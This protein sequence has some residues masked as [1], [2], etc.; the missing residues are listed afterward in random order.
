MGIPANFSIAVKHQLIRVDLQGDWNSQIDMEYLTELMEA[1]HQTK[2]APWGILVDM[3][4]WR[5]TD[6]L[7]AFKHNNVLHLDR[8]NQ[9]AECWLVEDDDQGSHLL[10]F[11]NEAKMPF[12]KCY[13]I[14]SAR[15]WLAPYGFPV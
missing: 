11:I 10:H 5:V 2:Q 14:E 4:G 12:K 6:E 13:D 7:K 15:Q 3:R 9:R 8:R 1:I